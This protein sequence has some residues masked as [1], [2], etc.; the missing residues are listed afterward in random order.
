MSIALPTWPGP[1][2]VVPRLM[3]YGGILRPALGGPTQRINRLGSRWAIDVTMPPMAEAQGRVWIARLVA[4]Q[5][6]GAILE[7]P[8]PEFDAGAPGTIL[9]DGAAQ[10]GMTLNLD[11][12]TPSYVAREGQ[13][14]GMPVAGRNYLYQVRTQTVFTAGAAALPIQPMIRKS[15]ADNAECEF[16]KP[17]IEGWI[18]GDELA[19]SRSVERHYG[20]QF[21]IEEAA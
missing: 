14:F 1:Q 18:I 7:W 11:G 19:W 5:S 4:G 17:L 13:F 10:T 16:G 6:E 2:S 15:P 3:Q 8:Q 21:T 9:V 12:A 20:I